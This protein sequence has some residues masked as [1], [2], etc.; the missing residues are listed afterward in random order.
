MPDPNPMSY[1][2]EVETPTAPV[3][4]CREDVNSRLYSPMAKMA[5]DRPQYLPDH[6]AEDVPFRL[7]I[8]QGEH[9]RGTDNHMASTLCMSSWTPSS[10]GP[11]W[12]KKRKHG[13]GRPLLIG[14]M[15]QSSYSVRCHASKFTGRS[16]RLQDGAT[17]Q[18][19]LTR[20]FQPMLAYIA[21]V[22]IAVHMFCV[23]HEYHL[24]R[25]V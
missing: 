2:Y 9:V 16:R 17:S 5:E 20:A 8:E 18:S 13:P 24:F 7:G 1:T 3:R 12:L 11:V 14:A 19:D 15:Q 23:L 4:R 25:W 22:E 10:P 21:H 6:S